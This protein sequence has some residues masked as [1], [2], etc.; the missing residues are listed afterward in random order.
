MMRS[1]VMWV[2]LALAAG[3]WAVPSPERGANNPGP[4]AGCAGR[5]A[6]TFEN[7]VI[8]TCRLDAAGVAEEKE[9][10]RS[11]KGQAERV[12]RSFV[13]KFDDDRV[14]R[15]T[16]IGTQAVVEHWCPSAQYPDGPRVLGIAE[17]TR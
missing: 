15:W 11:A 2:A 10:H 7:G 4:V 3:A 8:E 12:G 17:R 9:M 1:I 16:P 13:I 6:V 5:W 14:E